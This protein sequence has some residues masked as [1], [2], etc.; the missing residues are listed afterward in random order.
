MNLLH[1]VTSLYY[2]TS[3]L[4]FVTDFITSL[5]YFNEFHFT[6]TSL[7]NEEESEDKAIASD[8]RE[9]QD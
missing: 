1:F 5:Y 9:L 8:R 3:L 6:L 4:H 2:F 7:P